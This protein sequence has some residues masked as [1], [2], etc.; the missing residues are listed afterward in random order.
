ME[1][2]EL[3][4]VIGDEGLPD[5]VAAALAVHARPAILLEA[6]GDPEGLGVTK[7]G[8]RPDLPTGAP[9]PTLPGRDHPFVFLLQVR[10]DELPNLGE[11]PRDGLLSVSIGWDPTCGELDGPALVQLIDNDGSLEPVDPPSALVAEEEL[12]GGLL[13]EMAL[14][15]R[16]TWTVPRPT[17]L[18]RLESD[19]PRTKDWTGLEVPDGYDSEVHD[20]LVDALTSGQVSGGPEAQLLGWSR[21]D[22]EGTAGRHASRW[23][24]D[25]PL[26][27]TPWRLLIQIPSANLVPSFGDGGTGWVSLPAED[28]DTRRWNRTYSGGETL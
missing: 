13:R 3:V 23:D 20:Y 11:L 15:P 21:G 5:S 17:D 22:V 27:R 16:H 26:A 19:L 8:G 14:Y 10:L 9:W 4:A 1:R 25:G 7:G 12:Y 24:D 6:A 18:L 2:E 28:L